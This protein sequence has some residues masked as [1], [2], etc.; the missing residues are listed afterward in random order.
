[1]RNSH[2]VESGACDRTTLCQAHKPVDKPRVEF[3]GI[4]KSGFSESL[5]LRWREYSKRSH[6]R[7]P[8]YII[9]PESVWYASGW[10]TVVGMALAFVAIVTPLQIGLLEINI[11]ALLLASLLIDSVFLID[12]ILQFF[13]MISVNTYH[14]LKREVRL[15]KIAI[16]YLKRWFVVDFLVVIPWDL[17]GTP[18]KRVSAK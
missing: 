2:V 18:S 11:D 4:H 12:L 5:S 1:M 7:K 10:Q 8:W 3:P 16:H 14:G 9:D 15:N 6:V 13:V 17:I